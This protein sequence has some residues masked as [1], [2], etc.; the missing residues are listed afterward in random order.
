MPHLAWNNGAPSKMAY[1][2]IKRAGIWGW[3]GGGAEKMNARMESSWA[4]N[5][6]VH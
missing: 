1:N 6:T 2:K 5:R 3:G 4:E